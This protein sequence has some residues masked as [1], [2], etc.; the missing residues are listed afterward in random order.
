M[1]ALMADIMTPARRSALMSRIRGRDTKPEMAVRRMLHAMG[2]RYCL[3]RPDL[4]GRPDVVLP[5][6]Q[7]VVQVNGCFFHGH[8][9]PAFRLPSSNLEF[10]QE[11]IRRN[12]A[13]DAATTAA[14]VALGWRV[15]TVW[16]C[17]LRGRGK[18]LSAD[19]GKALGDFVHGEEVMSELAGARDGRPRTPRQP[20]LPESQFGIK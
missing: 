6:W 20:L 10:W 3:H 15:M 7:A 12:R 4:P 19:F 13:R 1:L 14:L 17:A 18:L 16:E 8:D 11:K 9:C 5:R 2:F